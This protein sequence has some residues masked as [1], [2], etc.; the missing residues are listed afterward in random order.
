MP[1]GKSRPLAK[2][3]TRK[4]LELTPGPCTANGWAKAATGTTNTASSAM[5]RQMA[6]RRQ[7]WMINATF[8]NCTNFLDGSFSPAA[9]ELARAT[10]SLRFA[11]CSFSFIVRQPIE[12]QKRN[13]FITGGTGYLGRF[14]IPELAGRGHELTA[15]VRPGSE[16]R[17]VAGA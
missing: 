6:L 7:I 11:R 13:I 1:S 5:P 17:L 9:H 14:L 3:V 10:K 2:T 16:K 12:V 4:S 15:L 8:M